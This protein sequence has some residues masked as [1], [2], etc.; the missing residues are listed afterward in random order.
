MS[1][2]IEEDVNP[3]AFSEAK[4]TAL[5]GHAIHDRL[6]FLRVRP[7]LEPQWFSNPGNVLLYKL[8]K[9]F[10]EHAGRFPQS[11]E[12][13][14]NCPDFN[15]E[16][17]PTRLKISAAYLRTEEH[18]PDFGADLLTQEFSLWAQA[19]IF[20][21]HTEKAAELFNQHRPEE[22]IAAYNEGYKLIQKANFMDARAE[23][24]DLEEF[25]KQLLLD[26]EQGLTFGIPQL[27][28]KLNPSAPEGALLRGDTTVVMAPSNIGKSTSLITIITHNIIRGKFVL[29]LTH[30]GK[31]ID[32]KFKVLMCILQVT[33]EEFFSKYLDTQWRHLA[34]YWTVFIDQHLVYIPMNSAFQGIREVEATVRQQQE[35]RKLQTG[36]GFDLLVDDYPQLLCTEGFIEGDMQKRTNDEQVY[37]CFV[38]MALDFGFHA[39]L[40]IQ[41]NRQGSKINR[42]QSSESRLLTME[43]VAESFGVMM[44][45]TNVLTLNISPYDKE[46]GRVTWYLCKSRSSDVDWAFVCKSDFSRATTHAPAGWPEVTPG[47]WFPQGSSSSPYVNME[48]YGCTAYRGTESSTAQMD[49]LLDQC[50]G[51]VIDARDLQAAIRGETSTPMATKRVLVTT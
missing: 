51:G 26:I 50:R 4:Q 1:R 11:P 32:L 22:A 36:A 33:R 16:E 19:I 41:T 30:E 37:G 43:D 17:P 3:L 35:Q 31:P 5:L 45:A 20:E 8:L 25:H 38:S 29:Y 47:T 39:L 14:L 13:L 10:Y 9:D 44:K 12:E 6:F 23:S 42:G 49:G 40:A 24:W 7:Y 18:V 34:E 28:A 21:Q 48:R 2:H 27:D 46:K 15:S